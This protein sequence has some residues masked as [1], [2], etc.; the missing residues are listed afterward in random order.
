[1]QLLLLKNPTLWCRASCWLC[2][3]NP[4]MQR[5]AA[6]ATAAAGR[7][8]AAGG[9]AA[10]AQASSRGLRY[11]PSVTPAA[12]N[13]RG[14]VRFAGMVSAP[15][16]WGVAAAAGGGGSWALP[17]VCFSPAAGPSCCRLRS[18]AVRQQCS[19]A[20]LALNKQPTP[21]LGLPQE[22]TRGNLLVLA[23]GAACTVWLYDL[24][25]EEREAAQVRSHAGAGRC[26]IWWC[27]KSQAW[28]AA[29]RGLVSF[30]HSSRLQQFSECLVAPLLLRRPSS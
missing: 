22:L 3:H 26:C 28:P 16:L 30:Q 29:V 8:A 12:P 7:A 19:R 18:A 14:I 27:S 1:M 10:A 17:A 21:L 2:I 25:Y 23:V 13:S 5:L 6:G 11:R 4:E 9:V 24:L 20:L 15:A